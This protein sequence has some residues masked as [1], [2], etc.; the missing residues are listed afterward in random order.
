ML[1]PG[2]STQAPAGDEGE[3]HVEHSTFQEGTALAVALQSLSWVPDPLKQVSSLMTDT[4]CQFPE[5]PTHLIP[6][7]QFRAHFCTSS[8]FPTDQ[9]YGN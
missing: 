3:E 9:V 4:S 7:S 8:A 6:P 1:P 2:Q 5:F